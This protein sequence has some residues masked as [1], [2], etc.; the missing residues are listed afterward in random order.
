MED[1]IHLIESFLLKFVFISES[2]RDQIDLKLALKA[3]PYKIDDF[4]IYRIEM[5]NFN[6]IQ[7]SLIAFQNDD[8]DELFEYYDK[9]NKIR[10]HKLARKATETEGQTQE[11]QKLAN[12]VLSII[13]KII[14]LGS[15]YKGDNVFNN[16]PKNLKGLYKDGQ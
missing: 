6:M 8:Q 3:L 9:R 1:E 7:K 16:V 12:S 10:L 4:N 11:L 15:F 5:I 14:S 2:S 13:N